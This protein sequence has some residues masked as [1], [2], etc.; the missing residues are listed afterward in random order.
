M[1]FALTDFISHDNIALVFLMVNRLYIQN[2]REGVVEIF[3]VNH[4]ALT[5]LAF[6]TALF[7]AGTGVTQTEW[8]KHPDG[9]VI[10][11]GVRGEWYRIHAFDPMVLFDG[12]E[13][14][15][16]YSGDDGSNNRIGYATSVD[17][18]AWEK[19][20]ANPVVDIGPEGEFDGVYASSCAVLL[21]DGEYKMWYCGVG[22]HGP[23]NSKIGYATSADGIIWNKH[24][25]NPV[26]EIGANG[27]WDSRRVFRP[28]VIFDGAEY[29]MWFSGSDGSHDRIGYA[30]SVDGIAWEKHPGNPIIDIGQAGMWNQD[31]VGK[32]SVLFH[33][34]EYMMWYTG[35]D[36]GPRGKRYR[37][38][39]ATSVD[40]IVW[41][42]H[43]DNPVLNLGIT[44]TWDSN[45]ISGASVLLDDSGYKMWYHG[46]NGSRWRIGHAADA[47]EN[48][49][50]GV[51]PQGKL[52]ITWAKVK[53]TQILQK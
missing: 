3:T 43:A 1:F 8:E 19:H 49:T 36:I 32:P 48:G 17:G 31:N 7:Y 44:G 29:R 42:E 5:F 28:T 25:D 16:W 40:G 27:S 46:F 24:P 39:Y 35:H 50:F 2:C 45:R 53:Q 51:T 6:I 21:S 33:N 30:T 18:I 23:A 47:N 34:G 12:N 11:V 10:D 22:D 52:P 9:A 4:K 13:Y 38:G 26:L 37:I 41:A 20:P 14:K 15:M